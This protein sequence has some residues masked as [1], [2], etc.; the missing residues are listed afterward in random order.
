MEEYVRPHEISDDLAASRR[1]QQNSKRP[2]KSPEMQ[3][4]GPLHRMTGGPSAGGGDGASG[5]RQP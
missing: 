2:Y 4:F 1:K 5:M 3:E